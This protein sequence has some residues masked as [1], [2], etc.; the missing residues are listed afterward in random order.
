RVSNNPGYRVS[1]QTSLG[2]V[3]DD[4]I[5]PNMKPWSGDHC[6]L[7]PQWVKGM[8]ISNKKLGENPN[9]IDVAPSVL[10]FLKINPDG[11][12]GKVFEIK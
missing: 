11:M 6:S 10:S 3:P 1:W 5:T 2:G 7:D 12:E 9:I 8:I 4:L